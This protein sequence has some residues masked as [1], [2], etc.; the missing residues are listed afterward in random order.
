MPTSLD[1]ILSAWTNSHDRLAAAVSPLTA[2]EVADPAYPTEWSIAQVLSHLGSGAEIFS[3]LLSSGLTGSPAPG[4]DDFTAVWDVWN[5]KSPADQA[6]DGLAADATF[7]AQVRET[8]PEQRAEFR[9]Q[10]FNGEQ[11]LA[12][13]AQMRLNEHAVHTWDVV[14]AL[15]PSATLTPDAAALLV[16]ALP[17]TVGIAGKPSAAE[18]T[19]EVQTTEPERSFALQL[20]GEG[21]TLT[22]GA[23]PAAEATLQLPAEALVRLVYGR[24]DPDHTPAEVVATGIDLADLRQV[25]PGF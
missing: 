15:D 22:P 10:M 4:R 5:A 8:T 6:T 18:L 3:L 14:V 12:G 24:L 17:P 9:V 7:L 25:F 19:I 11:D 2:A 20:N 16:D 13:L 23:P 21:T 1:P